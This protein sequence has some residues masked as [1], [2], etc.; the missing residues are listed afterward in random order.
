MEVALD[1]DA[2]GVGEEEGKIGIGAKSGGRAV[3]KFVF[4]YYLEAIR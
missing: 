4:S 1:D 3:P 2:G